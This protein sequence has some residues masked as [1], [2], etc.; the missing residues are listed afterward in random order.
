IAGSSFRREA[1]RFNDRG[2]RAPKVDL[3]SYAMQI[4]HGQQRFI[5]GHTTYGAHRH[6]INNFASRG[7]SLTLPMGNRADFSV[8][9]LNGTNIVGWDNFF[10]IANRRHQILSGTLGFEIFPERR[11]GLRLEAGVLD[12]WVEPRSGFNQGSVTDAERSRGLSFRLLLT[13]K[14]Q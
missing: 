1:L 3:S 9:A 12:G 4:Q 8:A 11:G 14:A 10:G 2:V 5:A 13:D 7:L 6:L